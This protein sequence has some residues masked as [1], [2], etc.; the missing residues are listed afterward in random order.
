MGSK[1]KTTGEEARSDGFREVQGYALEEAGSL[2]FSALKSICWLAHSW[3][4]KSLREDSI[5]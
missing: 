2:H 3:R 5:D 4:F 1:A